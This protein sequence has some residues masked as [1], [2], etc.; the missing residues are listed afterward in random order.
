MTGSTFNRVYEQTSPVV[1]CS[2]IGRMNADA[3]GRQRHVA[4]S[5]LIFKDAHVISSLRWTECALDEDI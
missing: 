1:M 5:V 4:L 3:N 2:N